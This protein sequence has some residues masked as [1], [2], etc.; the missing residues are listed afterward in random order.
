M[1]WLRSSFNNITMLYIMLVIV[2]VLYSLEKI[3][4]IARFIKKIATFNERG[5]SARSKR[6]T[7]EEKALLDFLNSDVN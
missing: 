5:E 4:K 2:C 6:M 1:Q 7:S 3:L